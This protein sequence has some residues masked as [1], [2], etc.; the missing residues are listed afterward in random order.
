MG[1]YATFIASNVIYFQKFVDIFLRNPL[2]SLYQESIV[3]LLAAYLLVCFFT[4]S[5]SMAVFH[6]SLVPGVKKCNV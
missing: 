4:R 3:L 6:S 5:T 2:E 1:S